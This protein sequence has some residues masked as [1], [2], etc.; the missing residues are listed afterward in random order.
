MA[1]HSNRQT[2][3]LRAWAGQVLTT[4]P[5]CFCTWN[6]CRSTFVRCTVC[7][8][9][10]ACKSRLYIEV[11]QWIGSLWENFWNVY[12][13]ATNRIKM[14]LQKI[15]AELL[16]GSV[17]SW[18]ETTSWLSLPRQPFCRLIWIYNLDLHG[19]HGLQ[20]VQ[21]ANVLHYTQPILW[22]SIRH[23]NFPTAIWLYSSILNV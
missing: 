8:P 5:A 20:T 3:F 16:H 9:C 6:T 1:K 22:S 10:Q 12:C 15:T 23:I 18:H 11:T 17:M 19:Q 4:L 14:K 13:F 2:V 7:K 21:R